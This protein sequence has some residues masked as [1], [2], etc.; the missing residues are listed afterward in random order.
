MSEEQATIVIPK[1]RQ[2]SDV[3]MPLTLTDNGVAVDWTSLS[4]IVAML[5][6]N[7]QRVLTGRCT[8][9]IDPEDTTKLVCDYDADQ[10]EFLG[11]TSIVIRCTYLERTKTFDKKVLEFVASTEDLDGEDITLEAPLPDDPLWQKLLTSKQQG[12]FFYDNKDNIDNK[13][14]EKD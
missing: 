13:K 6:S 8:T 3:R 4:D 14:G 10:P 7:E 2:G 11:L 1:V 5:Y 9:A 12:E